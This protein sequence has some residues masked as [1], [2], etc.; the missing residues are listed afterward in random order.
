[1]ALHILA[2]CA[3]FSPVPLLN[4]GAQR[5][6]RAESKA[7]M[8][9]KQTAA[10]DFD[11]AARKD[12]AATPAP[13]ARPAGA[14]FAPIDITVFDTPEVRGYEQTAEEAIF[15]L[16]QSATG[17]RLMGT[18]IAADYGIVFMDDADKNL[19]GYVDPEQKLVF[20]ARAQDPRMLAL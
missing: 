15:I 5:H 20:L 6:R 19:R 11:A 1:M 18:A 12:G 14:A 2:R 3:S 9:P 13:Y 10:P 16:S 4:E 7:R 17:R 8:R